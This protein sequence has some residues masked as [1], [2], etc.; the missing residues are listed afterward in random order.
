MRNI[1]ISDYRISRV[2]SFVMPE[3]YNN[4]KITAVAI[5]VTRDIGTP[6]WPPARER[7]FFLLQLFKDLGVG[8][9]REGIWGGS[10][11][12]EDLSKKLDEL[13]FAYDQRL[14]H[15]LDELSPV[16][17]IADFTTTRTKVQC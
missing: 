7:C 14:D 5:G 17:R 1:Q 6:D 2:K 3:S 12:A 9:D 8:E 15:L 11:S 13:G 10:I 16:G 4:L